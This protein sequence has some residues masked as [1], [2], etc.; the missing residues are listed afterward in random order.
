MT[1]FHRSTAPFAGIAAPPLVWIAVGAAAAGS[2]AALAYSRAG[3]SL[4]HYDARGHLVVAR[5]IA[6]S[7]TPGWQQI[8]AVWL[9]L[10]HL[11]NAGPVQIEA[12]YRSGASAIAL[13]VL[14]FAA[15]A[16]GI[17]HIVATLTRSW[18]AATAAAALFVMN[19]SLLYLQSTPMTE[20]L[21]L[22]L[23]IAAVAV[24][25]EWC[26]HGGRR[27]ARRAGWLFALACLTRYEAWPVT[28]AALGAA[29]LWRFNAF[30]G[31]SGSRFP[32]AVRDVLHIAA[33]PIAAIVGFTIFSRVVVGSWYARGFFV[34]DNPAQGHPLAASASILWGL[35]EVGGTA[36]LL[37]ASLGAAILL[38]RASGSR[39]DFAG[40]VP[41]ALAATAAV[42]F[43][44]FVAG[45]PYRI[46]YVVPLLAVEAICAGVALGAWKPGR[47]WF[48]AALV[49]VA[50]FEIPPMTPSPVVLEAQWDVPNAAARRAV[51]TCLAN[52]Y[53][54]ETIMASMGSLGHYMQTLSREGFAIRDFLHEGNGDIWLSALDN[55]RPYAGWILTEERAEGGDM[56]ATAART[57]PAFLDGFERACAGGG[58]VLY[59]R[60]PIPA[61]ARSDHSRGS[62]AP[63]R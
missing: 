35:R 23:T 11:L 4:S 42:P 30:T 17:A 14:A 7:I 52:G 20:P 32:T 8:G 41:L 40:V 62:S 5:R 16:A 3:L 60:R 54:G 50:V 58:V 36:A 43:T 15:A 53:A 9:P 49:G 47:R 46:R 29:T 63:V 25:L 48:A 44:A 31:E 34:P 55:P 24:L 28:V 57:R 45:H 18:V 12:F 21:F 61:A 6:D 37:A 56:L 26:L 10:P 13:S 38:V 22:G 51:T 19:P 33:Y 27:D 39:R 1:R 2:W 59:R